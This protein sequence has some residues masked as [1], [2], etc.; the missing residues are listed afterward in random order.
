MTKQII[1]KQE[2]EKNYDD[3]LQMNNKWKKLE[4]NETRE[5]KRSL[6]YFHSQEH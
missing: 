1:E 6:T 4:T 2:K 5:K 3:K